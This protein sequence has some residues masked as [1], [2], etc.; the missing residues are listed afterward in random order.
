MRF[1][2]NAFVARSSLW[3]MLCPACILE[4]VFKHFASTKLEFWQFLFWQRSVVMGL[5][6]HFCNSWVH[7]EEF[8]GAATKRDLMRTYGWMWLLVVLNPYGPSNRQ[9]SLWCTYMK[10]QQEKKHHYL[11]HIRDIEHSFF[12]NLVFHSVGG[13]AKEA[14]NFYKCLTS[15]LAKKLDQ[16]YCITMEWLHCILSFSLPQSSIQCLCGYCS[17]WCPPFSKNGTMHTF[18]SDGHHQV[19]ESLAAHRLSALF[20]VFLC[21]LDCK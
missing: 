1:P 6:N 20:Y 2:P 9:S 15:L 3:I 18:G 10:H 21:Y 14:T 12:P 8:V 7:G 17:F 5:L 16:H 19:K 11:Q 4:V 13:M